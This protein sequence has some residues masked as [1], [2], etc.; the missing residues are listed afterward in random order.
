MDTV[1]LR[2]KPGDDLKKVLEDY[3]KT[4]K[5]SATL[6]TCVGGLDRA[7]LRMAGAKPDKQDVRE[8]NFKSEIVSLVGTLSPDGAHLH[9]A[10]SD[11]EGKVIGGHLK[12]GCIINPTAEVTLLVE[13]DKV[14]S[15]EYDKNT[16]FP[17]LVIKDRVY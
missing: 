1:V 3:A 15:R 10:I 17:E 5:L 8:Y 6:V 7:V 14:F 4:K 12:D 16:G 2:L 13:V 9:M 11:E